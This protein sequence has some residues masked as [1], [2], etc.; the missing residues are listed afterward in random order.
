V[1]WFSFEGAQERCEKPLAAALKKL[2]Q[3]YDDNRVRDYEP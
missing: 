3:W 1:Y 2:G